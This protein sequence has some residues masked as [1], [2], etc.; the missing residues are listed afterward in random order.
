MCSGISLLGIAIKV[1]CCMLYASLIP[2]R[3]SNDGLTT[4][5]D[6]DS[7]VIR[8]VSTHLTSFAVLVDVNGQGEEVNTVHNIDTLKRERGA[9]HPLYCSTFL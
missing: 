1:K 3:W 5:K 9:A 7:N 6:S 8:C 4:T 2:R